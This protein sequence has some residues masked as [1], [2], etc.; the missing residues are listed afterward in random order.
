M[1]GRG[2]K[3]S[4]QGQTISRMQTLRLGSHSCPEERREKKVSA[5]ITGKHPARAVRAMGGRGESKNEPVSI[6]IAKIRHRPAPVDFI[7]KG[8]PLFMRHPF[9]PLHEA[10]AESTLDELGI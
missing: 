8:C 3:S 5:P 7:T 10:R 1:R 9:P 2:N 4:L 6:R